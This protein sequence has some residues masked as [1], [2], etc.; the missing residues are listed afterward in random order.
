[1]KRNKIIKYF[2]TIVICVFIVY[3]IGCTRHIKPVKID[4]EPESIPDFNGDDALNVLIPENAEKEYLV[5]YVNPGALSAK[6][7][8]DLNDLYKIAKELI[9]KELTRH[10]V[11]LSPDANK[12]LKFTITKIQWDLWAKGIWSGIYLEFEIETSDGYNES[13]KVMAHSVWGTNRQIGGAVTKAVE[14]IFQDRSILS[15]IEN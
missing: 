14:K 10:Q 9:E 8:V 11:P 12:Y 1:M 6:I 5:E 3:P 15:Y 7:Y 13:Y 2:I 4:F